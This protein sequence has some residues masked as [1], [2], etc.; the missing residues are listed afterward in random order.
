MGGGGS[1]LKHKILRELTR[2]GAL[3]EGGRA[4]PEGG[5]AEGRGRRTVGP[6]LGPRGLL[7]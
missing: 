3:G 2:S 6:G 1:G 7:T 4:E 5:A